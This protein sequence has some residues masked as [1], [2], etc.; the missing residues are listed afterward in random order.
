MEFSAE[1]IAGLIN[2]KVIGDEKAVITGVS[3]I[4][5][6]QKGH[7]SFVGQSRFSHYIDSTECAVLI[8]SQDLIEQDKSYQPTII[9]VEDA[10]LSFQIL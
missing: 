5:N 1:Q 8:V 2:G 10:Y 4:E 6:G 7:L 3:P 9:V